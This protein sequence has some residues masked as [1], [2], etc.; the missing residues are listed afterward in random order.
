MPRLRSRAE[1]RLIAMPKEKEIKR[2][3]RSGNDKIL[4]GICGGLAEYLNIDPVIMRLIW[5]AFSLVYGAGILV[6]IIAWV[7]IPRNPKHKWVG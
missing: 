2:L 4:G 7:I 6:Y 5:I 3:Y 1:G